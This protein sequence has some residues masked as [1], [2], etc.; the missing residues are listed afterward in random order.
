MWVNSLFLT[1]RILKIKIWTTHFKISSSWWWWWTYPNASKYLGKN[2]SLRG[3]VYIA[4]AGIIPYNQDN[5]S[6]TH[7]YSWNSKGK[8]ITSVISKAIDI[9]PEI[10]KF[11]NICI[12]ILLESVLK[13]IEVLDTYQIARSFPIIIYNYDL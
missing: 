1:R 11:N 4:T 3:F 7:Q 10:I 2:R 8:R 6:D 13:I 12:N 9:F 5:S